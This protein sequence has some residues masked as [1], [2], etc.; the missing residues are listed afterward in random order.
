ML[1]FPGPHRSDRKNITSGGSGGGGGT[2]AASLFGRQH[3][4]ANA[5]KESLKKERK[6]KENPDMPSV[7]FPISVLDVQC[8]VTLLTGQVGVK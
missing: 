5:E 1:C 8:S 2:V 4:A 7:C 3:N 6:K